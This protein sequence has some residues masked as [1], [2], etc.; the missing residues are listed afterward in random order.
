MTDKKCS[1]KAPYVMEMEA[2]TYAWCACGLT[3]KQPFC[4]GAHAGTIL[5]P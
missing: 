1:Q 2:G 4:D 3:K 5:V